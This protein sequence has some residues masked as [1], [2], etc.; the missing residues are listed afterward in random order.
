MPSKKII[1]VSEREASR[2]R[3]LINFSSQNL[4]DQKEI[5]Q[6][7]KIWE[8][9]FSDSH[10]FRIVSFIRKVQEELELDAEVRKSLLKNLNENLS[11]SSELLGVDPLAKL[12]EQREPVNNTV[13]RY[14]IRTLLTKLDA[15]EVQNLQGVLRNYFANSQLDYDTQVAL[16]NWC[17]LLS[18]EDNSKITAHVSQSVMSKVIDQIYNYYCDLFGP[19]VT[20]HTFAEAIRSTEA[21]PEAREFSPR[22][23]F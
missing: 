21:I 8:D 7:I 16:I 3:R 9:N 6:L 5:L 15:K 13:F 14:L 19:V 10:A 1:T 22:Q 4:L 17:K 20:D 11:K 12:P 18:Q 2:R 23:L